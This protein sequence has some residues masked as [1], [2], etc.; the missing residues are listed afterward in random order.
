MVDIL[1]KIGDTPL[2]KMEKFSFKSNV[3]AKLEHLNPSGSLKDRIAHEMIH[4]AE[5]RGELKPGMKI[6]EATSGNTGI[7]FAMVSAAL[8]YE[9]IAIMPKN[10]TIERRQMVK[11]FGG[12]VIL[13]PAREEM[14]GPVKKLDEMK[15]KLKDKAWFPSQFE[16]FDNVRAHYKT[17]NEIFDQMKKMKEKID[18]FV[19][20]V[21]TGGTIVGV[22]TVLKKKIKGVTVIAVEPEE[23]AALSGGKI[24]HHDIQ[25]IGEGFVPKIFDYEV[26]DEIYRIKSKDAIKITKELAL[27]EGIFGGITSGANLAAAIEIQKRKEFRDCNIVTLVCDRGERYLSMKI[28]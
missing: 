28:W 8:G 4:Q 10:V 25:G 6:I 23:C 12:K 19:M 9:F 15:K 14:F 5:K 2:V 24:G 21:G 13:T 3:F 22:G 27:K 18:V 16:N 26:V 1:H 7:S 17:G 20:G 11:A